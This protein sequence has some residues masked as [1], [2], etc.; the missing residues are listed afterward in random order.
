MGNFHSAS[1]LSLA[2]DNFAR[3]QKGE[4]FCKHGILQ[5]NYIGRAYKVIRA[6]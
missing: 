3:N 5:S 4:Y 1:I 2:T 6:R